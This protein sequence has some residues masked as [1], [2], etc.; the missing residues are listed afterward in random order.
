MFEYLCVS[1]KTLFSVTRKRPENTS[2]NYFCSQSCSA[3]YNNKVSPKRT[4]RTYSCVVCS[5]KTS[6]RTYYCK[7]CKEKKHGSDFTLEEFS[8]TGKKHYQVFAKARERARKQYLAA[9]PNPC[10]EKCK[11][12][13][14]IEVCHIKSISSFSKETLV[15]VINDPSNLI[16]LCPNCHWE[17]DHPKESDALPTELYPR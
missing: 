4:K 7:T 12:S 8:Y 10:C 1:C 5:I 6:K 11:Y 16:G 9:H 13:Y 2:G 17:M 14:H 15:S 3:S